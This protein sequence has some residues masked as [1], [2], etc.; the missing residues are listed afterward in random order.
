MKLP[1]GASPKKHW[2][3]TIFDFQKKIRWFKHRVALWRIAQDL[4]E[5]TPLYV[6]AENLLAN[7]A[8]MDNIN[9]QRESA[10]QAMLKAKNDQERLEAQC[11]GNAIENII[12]NFRRNIELQ[13]F[14][15]AEEDLKIKK[16]KKEG[17]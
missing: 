7:E 4:D 16:T 15:Q 3:P 6:G 2:L 9:K 1:K 14:L 17:K 8:F 12:T 5:S 11:A 13:M 10:R